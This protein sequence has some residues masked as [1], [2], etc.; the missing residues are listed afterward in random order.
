M[1]KLITLF[2]TLLSVNAHALPDLIVQS[3]SF[4]TAT[5]KW[6]ADIKNQGDTG[7]GTSSFST[8]FHI[9]NIWVSAYTYYGSLAAGDTISVTGTTAVTPI[10]TGNHPVDTFVDN[11]AQVVESDE[12][13][14]HNKTDVSF[15]PTLPDLI[16]Q[17]HA[18]NTTTGQW[19]AVVK[20]QGGSE[21]GTAN[22]NTSFHIDNLITGN[23]L[24]TGSL[25][26]GATATVT[27]STNVTPIPTGT[28]P[29][30]TYVDNWALVT[31]SDETNNHNKTD[32][33][34][35][36]ASNTDYEVQGYAKVANV[37]GGNGANVINVTNCTDSGT[38]SDNGTPAAGTLRAALNIVGAKTIKFAQDCNITLGWFAWVNDNTTIDGDGKNIHI[39]GWPL[40]VAYNYG[41]N[42]STNVIIKN[43]TFNDTI[44]N[45]S[46]VYITSGSDN[47]WVDHNTFYDN[48]GNCNAT[49]EGFAIF[50]PSGNPSQGVTLSWNRW[51][52]PAGQPSSCKA[53]AIGASDNNAT[54]IRISIH[55]NYFKNVD[56]RHPRT[57]G[58]G[59]V[60]HSWNNVI[61]GWLE[62]GMG[63]SDAANMFAENNYF[64]NTRA[65]GTKAIDGLYNYPNYAASNSVKSTNNT[66]AGL[67]STIVTT[68]TFNMS[69]ITYSGYPI[70]NSDTIMRDRVIA[71]AG[72][73]N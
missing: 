65:S 33:S 53:I 4:D 36:I 25:A 58:A 2:I 37:T 28:H 6:S 43:I 41:S 46:A 22:F 31:E 57:H 71:G 12:T 30:D 42:A 23:A 3:H 70:E 50:D 48:T 73:N 27:A 35:P 69:W 66:L 26:A 11:A 55:H 62:Y 20:N 29:V 38:G 13:N 60:I 15:L 51:V 44:G 24:Y 47:I 1:N 10:P 21:T 52:T 9:D 7:T 17:S 49:G 39:M 63:S 32:V 72:A 67:P 59:I 18:F 68:G 14:N 56:A 64:N 8:S 45:Q 16:V 19:T 5:G 34:F 61:E 54:D 40:R